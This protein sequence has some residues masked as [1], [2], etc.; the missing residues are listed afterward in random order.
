[1]IVLKNGHVVVVDS[2]VGQEE[3]VIAPL[4]DGL[5][6]LDDFAEVSILGDGTVMLILSGNGLIARDGTA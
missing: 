1:M 5:K 4:E 6:H 2:F 3:V